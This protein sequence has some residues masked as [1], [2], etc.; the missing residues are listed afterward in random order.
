MRRNPTSI[1]AALAGG[2]LA[3]G[4]AVTFVM[5]GESSSQDP[6][7]SLRM[8]ASASQQS[9]RPSVLPDGGTLVLEMHTPTPEERQLAGC[10]VKPYLA[11]LR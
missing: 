11:D 3:S 10:F 9:S 8:R 5:L 4:V 7:A 2:V 6:C 1:V